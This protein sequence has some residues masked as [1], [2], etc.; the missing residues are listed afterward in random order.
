MPLHPSVNAALFSGKGAGVGK[1]P[2]GLG[3]GKTGIGKTGI[4]KTGIG[5]GKSAS[6]VVTGKRVNPLLSSGSGIGKTSVG[7]TSVGKTS[8]GKTNPILNQYGPKRKNRKSPGTA[9]LMEIRKYQGTLRNPAGTKG[10]AT[11]LLIRKGPFAR[12]VREIAN[13]AVSSSYAPDGLK[14]Q[15][16]AL[17]A[18][19]EATENYGVSLFADS[20]LE[21]IHAKRVTILPKDMQLARRVRGEIC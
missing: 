14:F 8:V 11:E 20:N 12:L 18:V 16:Q 15:T 4:G 19:Q 1:V 7:K 2:T 17:L 21:A 9:A 10:T 5:I 6:N 3:I 13:E